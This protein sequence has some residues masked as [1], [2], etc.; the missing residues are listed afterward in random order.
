MIF[1]KKYNLR[2]SKP[3]K[4]IPCFQWQQIENWT[5]WLLS[6]FI[7]YFCV[8]NCNICF[9]LLLTR[10]VWHKM[11]SMKII[12]NV[13][14]RLSK[15]EKKSNMLRNNTP[16]P[17]LY[18]K[19]SSDLPGQ[20]PPLWRWGPPPCDPDKRRWRSQRIYRSGYPPHWRW[21]NLCEVGKPGRE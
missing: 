14:L 21:W 11:Y 13:Y 10:I 4:N 20:H 18:L 17:H 5:A 2:R 3:H 6:N 19:R 1:L 9:W 15:Y 7:E 16:P 12:Y 8:Y